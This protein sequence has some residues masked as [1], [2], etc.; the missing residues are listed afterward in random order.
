MCCS[1][2][3]FFLFLKNWNDYCY[4][5]PL[6]VTLLWSPWTFYTLYKRCPRKAL[7]L[8]EAGWQVPCCGKLQ[9]PCSAPLTNSGTSH[10]DSQLSLPIS[11]FL[12]LLGAL[13][14]NLHVK[15][16]SVVST[17]PQKCHHSVIAKVEVEKASLP[18]PICLPPQAS[19]CLLRLAQGQRCKVAAW[20]VSIQGIKYRTHFPLPLKWLPLASCLYTC[21]RLLPL[22]CHFPFHSSSWQCIQGKGQ[23]HSTQ[24]SKPEPAGLRLSWTT[25]WKRSWPPSDSTLNGPINAIKEGLGKVISGEVISGEV[26]SGLKVDSGHPRLP[27]V[28]KLSTNSSAT[29]A[30]SH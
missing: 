22:L 12:L 24:E 8:V 20:Q 4:G 6:L 21:D 26:L 3:F 2:Y 16:S 18:P 23:P 13:S 25:K 11:H 1:G 14:T 9:S 27:W 29:H 19:C 5:P 17:R 30:K 10:P 7:L 28:Q 15:G